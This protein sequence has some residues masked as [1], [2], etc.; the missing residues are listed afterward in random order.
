MPFAPA[1]MRLPAAIRKPRP[2][3]HERTTSH[4]LCSPRTSPAALRCFRTSTMV[5]TNQARN[6]LNSKK[7]SILESTPSRNSTPVMTGINNATGKSRF[8]LSRGLWIPE[9]TSVR[10]RMNATLTTLL[11]RASPSAIWGVPARAALIETDNSGLEVANAATV[12]P[13]IPGE[14]RAQWA[15][16]TVPRTNSSPPMA[17]HTRPK[18]KTV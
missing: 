9:M 16:P 8:T 1:T 3:A 11:P 4:P 10:A 14:I 18:I 15:R 13:I 7:P 12:T 6:I 17:A 5:V 2:I